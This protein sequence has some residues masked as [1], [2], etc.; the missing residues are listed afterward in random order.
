MLLFD[1]P[2]P[3]IIIPAPRELIKPNRSLLTPDKTIVPAISFI[4][5]GRFSTAVTAELEFRTSAVDGSNLTTYSF[6]SQD[7]GAADAT[8]RVIVALSASGSISA[9]T[10]SSATIAGVG[11][12]IHV[13]INSIDHFSIFSAQVASGTTATISV[14]LSGACIRA[15][16]GI[17]RLINE[18]SGTPH[19]TASD[20]T[21][22]SNV[23]SLN[24]DVPSNGVLVAGGIYIGT[25]ATA[26]WSG[27]TERYDAAL[28]GGTTCHTGASETGLGSET[29]RAVSF[30]VTGGSS[31]SLGA[32]TWS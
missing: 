29:G 15:G 20:A 11:A 21:M 27:A 1:K 14:T 22:S 6:A 28:E 13:N 16:I 19:A 10:L 32:A 30:T 26:S 2:P 18:T 3:A 9:R 24:I 31:G 5:S 25:A 23:L 7:I 12:T 4:S 17:W 8:R